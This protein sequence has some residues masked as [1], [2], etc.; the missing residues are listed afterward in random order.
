MQRVHAFTI[1]EDHSWMCTVW[2]SIEYIDTLFHFVL[3][4]LQGRL[5]QDTREMYLDAVS[6]PELPL[7]VNI[8]VA[9]RKFSPMPI[10]NFPN[11]DADTY[12]DSITDPDA[13]TNTTRNDLLFLTSRTYKRLTMFAYSNKIILHS[14]KL[15]S[16]NNY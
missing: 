7:L 10:L 6:W 12:N 16:V 9:K 8:A 1:A 13:D 2:D 15:Y 4:L 14:G 5:G 11:A 3:G